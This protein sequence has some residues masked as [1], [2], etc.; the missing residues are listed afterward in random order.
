[1]AQRYMDQTI[2]VIWQRIGLS[3]RPA[4]VGRELQLPFRTTKA[5][6]LGLSYPPSDLA[7]GGAP[8]PGLLSQAAAARL[9]PPPATSQL[10]QL[11]SRRW[12]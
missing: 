3:D 9:A 10:F 4:K 1:M 6:M 12:L 7:I 8:A 11:P 2:T 5:F